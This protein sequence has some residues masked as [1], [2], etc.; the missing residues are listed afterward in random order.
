MN[1]NLYKSKASISLVFITS[2]F[3]FI[4]FHLPSKWGVMI[5]SRSSESL[6]IWGIKLGSTSSFFD[7]SIQVPN[8]IEK[9]S[10]RAHFSVKGPASVSDIKVFL[11]QE[12]TNSVSCK[13]KKAERASNCIL[14]IQI[15]ENQISNCSCD[16]LDDFK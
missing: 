4:L 11:N 5:T 6:K 10:E 9:P 15:S 1:S 13:L 16:V 3:A 14:V 7:H 2:I 8:R 12:M